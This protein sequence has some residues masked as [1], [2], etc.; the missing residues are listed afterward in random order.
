[1][2][3]PKLRF[4]EFT[5]EYR[6]VKFDDIVNYQKGFAF[7]SNDYKNNGI[8]I[9][10][11]SDTTNNSIKKDNPI[12]I[13]KSEAS[14]Y[15]NVE[16]LTNDIIISS[17]GSKPPLYD[18]MVGKVV[19]VPEFENGSLLNQNAIRFRAKYD[20]QIYIY[21]YLKQKKY[22]KFIENIMRGNANQRS[23]TLEDL[24]NFKLSIPSLKEQTKVANLLS[25]LE[26][27][28]ELQTQKIEVLKL[29]KKGLLK[30][31]LSSANTYK[32][33]KFV[34]T[35]KNGYAFKNNLYSNKGKYNILTISNVTGNKYIDTNFKNKYEILPTDLQ[36]HQLLKD[37]DILMSMTGN[38]GRVSLNKGNN[39]LLN[40][41]VGLIIPNNYV[42]PLYLFYVLSNDH[43]ERTM[44]NLSQGAA[45]ANISKEDIDNYKV[46]ILPID[47]QNKIVDLLNIYFD[48]LFLECQKLNEL[49]I[50]KKGLTQ[51]MF[52]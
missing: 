2:N 19:L 41:R 8:R 35:L 31:L 48:L 32:A 23:I 46:P 1:M 18:S 51:N 25:L 34:A 52:V 11:I 3:V 37:N 22:T 6:N 14:K 29:F 33:L 13:S 16:L 17:V 27:K 28:I 7:K 43:F 10:R 42:N 44:I 47:R 45:Q 26:K 38:V 49:K 5:A 4:K 24:L 12:Y 40:Q 9:I 36:P 50:L 30:K 15:K 39:N 20:N 21:N